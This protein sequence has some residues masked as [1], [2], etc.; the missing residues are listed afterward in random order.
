VIGVAVTLS[1]GLWLIAAGVAVAVTHP[2]LSGWTGI[3]AALVIAGG[4]LI[5]RIAHVHRY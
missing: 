4:A 5:A 3:A 1:V 2:P